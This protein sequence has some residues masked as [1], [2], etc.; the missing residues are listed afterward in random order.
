[1]AL[2]SDYLHHVQTYQA[3]YGPQTCVLY[4]CGGFYEIY[5]ADDGVVD[6]HGLAEL[7]QLQ[8]SRRN[9]S[10]ET[11]DRTN[12]LMAGF[13]EFA[14]PKFTKM[15]VDN[16]F[17]VVVVAQVSPP[18]KPR[19]E[20]VSV[21]SPGTTMEVR[22]P[23]D[24]NVVCS[25][26]VQH[27]EGG[28]PTIAAATADVT[29]GVIKLYEAGSTESDPALALDGCYR[30]LLEL[31]PKEFV[32]SGD[33]RA[34]AFA[35]LVA[36][37][38]IGTKKLHNLVNCYSPDLTR[39][40]F[41]N[42]VLRDAYPAICKTSAG[43]L[44]IIE[45]MDLERNPGSVA[46]LVQLL[47]FLRGHS[48][49]SLDGLQ[50]PL[51]VDTDACHLS[52]EYNSL[53]QLNVCSGGSGGG[54]LLRLLNRCITCPGRRLF[55]ERLLHPSADAAVI[56]ERLTAVQEHV[57]DGERRARVR[58]L[59]KDTCD[60]PRLL[61]RV[62]M[63]QGVAADFASLQRCLEAAS[64]LGALLPPLP[65]ELEPIRAAIS[66]AL[67]LDGDGADHIG[68]GLAVCRFV[69]G[70]NS[71]I[72]ELADRLAAVRAAFDCLAD[73]NNKWFKVEFS[74]ATGY[75]VSV[76]MRRF[77]DLCA[78]HAEVRFGDSSIPVQALE[79]RAISASSSVFRVTHAKFQAANHELLRTLDSYRT[80]VQQAFLAF[81]DCFLTAHADTLQVL[82]RWLSELDV[83]CTHAQNAVEYGYRRPK[84]V[85]GPHARVAV[86]GLR[87][88][89][90]ERIQNDT[91]YVVNDVS[92]GGNG[93]LLFGINCCGKSTL[94]KATALAVIM[95]QAGS[96][97]P[98]ISM[99][100]C[101]YEAIFTRIPSGDDMYR[102]MSTF[103]VELFELRKIIK[104]ATHNSLIVG[105][106]VAHGSEAL[107]AIAIVASSILHLC[108]VRASFIFA[109]HLHDLVQLPELQAAQQSGALSLFHLRVHYDE[110]LKALVYERKLEPGPGSPVYG[111]EVCRAFA[112]PDSFLAR[113]QA[114]RDVLMPS[115]ATADT[116]FLLAAPA[117]SRYSAQVS[118]RMCQVCK[119]GRATEV[120]HIL[121]QHLAEPDSGLIDAPDGR[122]IHKNR[123]F[124]L[125]AL[126]EACHDAVHDGRLEIAGYRQTS[127]GPMLVQM[128][129]GS[130]TAEGAKTADAHVIDLL[131]QG[132]SSKEVQHALGVSRYVVDKARRTRQRLIEGGVPAAPCTIAV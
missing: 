104:R 44:S 103:A 41:Q 20:V 31:A 58:A 126:C 28:A 113:A 22:S 13:P 46:A 76:T 130:R 23:D 45:V 89:V 69:R 42:Q 27:P 119:M 51:R 82:S 120:H 48:T 100:L 72:D 32:I 105:D 88:P 10:I 39:P 40:A 1:M 79:S 30:F 29:T 123:R 107:S 3:Q 35:N 90:V 110:V 127:A 38:N 87:H 57:D 11:V 17:T 52:V 49:R 85:Q 21:L 116:A 115:A 61:K 34:E 78:A 111:L 54:S 68:S 92:L 109:T 74:D 43:F 97:A 2:Y 26:F 36:A 95:A 9:K 128:P 62:H 101:P 114:I 16:N 56:E 91:P 86:Q 37:L 94:S 53:V 131:Q 25:M 73:G 19:R 64:A 106:E 112:F 122:R 121:P 6:I 4:Q 8:V 60:I 99:E 50:P 15:L 132:H 117:R 71:R 55:K 125:V 59:L 93:M 12:F 67:D 33:M 47:L 84:V 18:P 124:N 65:A 77:K 83:V 63:R 75:D 66:T 108:D 7:L 118:M 102:G 5:S 129:G 14:L 24:T 81:C 98:C 70:Y 80:E 96:F